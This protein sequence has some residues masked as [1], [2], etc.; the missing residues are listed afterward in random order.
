MMMP[1]NCALCPQQMKYTIITTNH[2]FC[3]ED[4]GSSLEFT[5]EQCANSKIQWTSWKNM[6]VKKEEA[7]PH[8]GWRM[9]RNSGN[10]RNQYLGTCGVAP[11]EW[12]WMPTSCESLINLPKPTPRPTPARTFRGW[13][14]GKR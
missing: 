11:K 13:A 7:S 1:T 9:C 14:G 2:H 3:A 4:H 8:M 10:N 5:G 12:P 6:A